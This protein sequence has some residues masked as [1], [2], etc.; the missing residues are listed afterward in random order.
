MKSAF[1]GMVLLL[2][3]SFL[4]A[5]ENLIKNGDFSDSSQVWQFNSNGATATGKI[6]F[7]KFQVTITNPGNSQWSPQL[8]QNGIPLVEGEAYILTFDAWASDSGFIAVS[9]GNGGYQPYIDSSISTI[10]VT[11]TKRTNTLVFAMEKSSDP[12]AILRFGF[13]ATKS[14]AAIG[15]D[16]VRLTKSNEPIIRVTAP[17][18][19][20]SWK[21]G[22]ENKISWTNTGTLE[23]VKISYT[24]DNGTS[25]TTVVESLTNMQ[26]FWWK[27]PDIS[28]STNCK[29]AVSSIDGKY[30]DTSDAFKIASQGVIDS[31]ELVLNGKFIDMSEWI[32]NSYSPAVA[33]DSII[34][35]E[36]AVLISKIGTDPWQIKL[37]QTGITLENRKAYE[38][39]FDAYASSDR[40]IY[41]NVGHSNGN[42]SWSINGGDSIAISVTA[43]KQRYSS[44]FVMNYP[45]AS[46]IFVEFNLGND[47]SDVFI[48]NVSLK[49][50]PAISTFFTYPTYNSVLKQ[51]STK[52][53]QW[54]TSEITPVKIEYTSDNGATWNL[55]IDSIENMGIY[56]WDIPVVSSESCFV[57]LKAVAND[58]V[59]GSSTRFLINKFGTFVKTGEMIINGNFDNGVSG[60]NSLTFSN[61]AEATPVVQNSIF[62][63]D[64]NSPGKEVSDIVLSQSNL[65]LLAGKK[66]F[67]S[68]MAFTA[69]NNSMTIRL[70]S[71]KESDGDTSFSFFDSSIQLPNSKTTFNFEITPE[72][73][74]NATI[75]FLIGGSQ[76]GVYLDNVSLQLPVSVEKRYKTVR[77]RLSNLSVSLAHNAV[78][79]STDQKYYNS[80][81]EILNMQG[82]HIANVKMISDRAYWDCK[83]TKGKSVSRGSYLAILKTHK[84]VIS[85]HFLIK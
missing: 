4:T 74:I 48:D 57:R 79:F 54:T 23:T 24:I 29:I 31:Q 17:V 20:T 68:F 43:S 38:L 18:S 80:K 5:Q 9:I 69:G 65:T 12:Q 2:Q 52:S 7:E 39:S 42:P 72:E 76:A 21:T 35:D 32:F 13:G 70:S 58:S 44:V 10:P 53:L 6:E 36:M 19:G 22:T 15:L 46:N 49:E 77:N 83:N 82:M 14:L 66:Y 59:L 27:I 50:I 33:A 63:L 26:K 30:S 41:A 28:S 62:G 67:L 55:V 84:G 81:I 25:W 75:E 45:T 11:Q 64:I 1:V 16:N 40:Q 61:G 34:N 85:R 51:G 60:W 47:T 37:Q 71:T 56:N 8:Q 78:I 73:D 3:I